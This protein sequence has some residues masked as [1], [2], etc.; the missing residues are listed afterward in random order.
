MTLHAGAAR[1]TITPPVGTPMAG[2]NARIEPAQGVHD[3]LFARALV[4]STGTTAVAL[5]VLDV[6]LVTERL[7]RAVQQAASRMTRIPPENIVVAAT[8]THSG[9]AG[10]VPVD[11]H[12]GAL[13]LFRPF[14]GAYDAALLHITAQRAAE[15]VGQAAGRQE[16]VDVAVGSASAEGVGA[17]R[18]DPGGPVDT[19]VVAIRLDGRDGRPVARLFSQGC[20]PTVLN[21]D[22]RRF[23]GDLVGLA[24]HRL[25]RDLDGAV[26]IGMTGSA[27]DVSTRATRRASTFAE[28]ERMAAIL[29]GAVQEAVEGSLPAADSRLWLK[30]DVFHS[31]QKARP[32]HHEL[33]ERLRRARRDLEEARARGASATELR[34]AA[35]DVEGV[36]FLLSGAGQPASTGSIPVD[37]CALQIGPA[38]LF[39]FPVELFAEPGLALREQCGA[40]R[41]L[42]ACYTNDYLGYMPSGRAFAA[43]G[44]EVDM[45]LLPA[46]TAEQMVTHA[47]ELAKRPPGERGRP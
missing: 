4:L 31:A 33:E 3:D 37:I 45:S 35:T 46:G 22:N 6:L 14:L 43:G 44:Y 32:T 19:D 8:H 28:A 12:D 2:Y 42:V 26:A 38:A 39:G 7:V 25:E 1:I 40:E 20:H 47:V 16:A 13:A 21:A 41:T 10:L 24:C 18:R 5:V 9:P 29:A 36:E 34:I 23:S 11:E 30:R 15:A 27:G 17:N